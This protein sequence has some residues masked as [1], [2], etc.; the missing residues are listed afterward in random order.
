MNTN[1]QEYRKYL[2][3]IKYVEDLE[4]V[5]KTLLSKSEF[6]EKVLIKLGKREDFT[7]D[8]ILEY[9]GKNL[10]DDPKFV[11]STF[12][13][14]I[15]LN[16]TDKNLYENYL[17]VVTYYYDNYIKPLLKDEVLSLKLIQGYK[18]LPILKNADFLEDVKQ[19]NVLDT[20][21]AGSTEENVYEFLIRNT[22]EDTRFKTP[23]II[24]KVKGLVGKT[25]SKFLSE[26]FVN[27]GAQQILNPDNDN[28]SD[29]ENQPLF[30]LT[31]YLN[32]DDPDDNERVVYWL[33]PKQP[34]NERETQKLLLKGYDVL[35]EK[36]I[37]KELIEH[38]LHQISFETEDGNRIKI[39]Y[40]PE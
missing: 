25:G 7:P 19:D 6:V 21:D 38:P 40:H 24:S 23:A 3:Q 4:N 30:S 16:Y 1:E 22:L 17:E 12:F 36:L 29:S 5:P 9:V 13:K 28:N 20:D 2:N 31:Y 11:I 35:K 32:E 27:S 26:Q 37:L 33:L 14:V 34:F 18:K 10:I 8:R 39:I 15:S